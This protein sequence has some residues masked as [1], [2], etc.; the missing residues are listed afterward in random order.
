MFE[1]ISDE[2]FTNALL[3]IVSGDDGS[4]EIKT[5]ASLSNLATSGL[6]TRDAL[7]IS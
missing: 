3:E 6:S 7:W 1:P 2:N 4:G 5:D